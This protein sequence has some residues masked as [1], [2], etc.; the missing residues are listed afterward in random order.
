MSLGLVWA[1]L[2]WASIFIRPAVP[3]DEIW[4]E[5]VAFVGDLLGRTHHLQRLLAHLLQVGSA[6]VN[7]LPGPLA[8]GLLVAFEAVLKL[9]RIVL[10][11]AHRLYTNDI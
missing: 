8:D 5:G 11:A 6:G 7:V 9:A 4:L 2:S 10:P 1:A 3:G